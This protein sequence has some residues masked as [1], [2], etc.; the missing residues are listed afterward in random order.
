MATPVEPF[1]AVIA[2]LEETLPPSLAAADDAGTAAFTRR[3]VE[4]LRTRPPELVTL[5]GFATRVLD[6]LRRPEVDA[7]Q[8]VQVIQ[9]DPALAAKVLSVSS[10]ALL[11]TASRG[12]VRTIRDAVV[13][14]GLREIGDIALGVA[15]R[16]L[17]GARGRIASRLFLGSRQRLYSEALTVA[18][19]A[20]ALADLV[21]VARPDHAFLG[22]ML[23]DL[24]KAATLDVIIDL[25]LAGKLGHR[26]DE[27]AVE[28]VLETT[29]PA[30]ALHI[31]A[32]WNMPDYLTALCDGQDLRGTPDEALVASIQLVAG[33]AALRA[34]RPLAPD[35][36]ARTMRAADTLRADGRLARVV[37]RQ[38]EDNER[39]VAALFPL[40]EA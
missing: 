3:V 33:L 36:H 38:L 11:G 9:Q 17:F 24:G 26:P 25:T 4:D 2:E 7:N 22:G 29:G 30:V 23:L 12:E 28:A 10:S 27:A 34:G 21:R 1:G 14:L 18:F 32:A 20:G 6:V 37:L 5:P 13:K 8:I 31:A 19:T 16:T 40:A 15:A 39:R 35:A